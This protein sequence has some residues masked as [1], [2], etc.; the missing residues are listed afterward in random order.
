MSSFKVGREPGSAT[1]P[2]EYIFEQLGL[3]AMHAGMAQTYFEAG[4]SPG[5]RYSLASLVAR[6]KA[7]A[8]VVNDLSARS[9]ERQSG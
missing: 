7:V 1:D 5:F 4:D 8:G 9:A 2:G 6:V 3:V